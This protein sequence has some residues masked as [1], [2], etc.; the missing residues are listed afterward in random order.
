M[1]TKPAGRVLR[2]VAVAWAA[3]LCL[4]VGFRVLADC[5]A[6]GLPF[7]D[8][9]STSFCAQIA[10][11]YYTEPPRDFRRLVYMTPASMAGAF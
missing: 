3:T 11:A 2:V 10:E 9:G 7:T 5:S 4:G 6:F 1:G 8:L